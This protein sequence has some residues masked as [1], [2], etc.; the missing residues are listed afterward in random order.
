MPGDRT[1]FAD[2]FSDTPIGDFP[3][4]LRFKSGEMEVVEWNGRSLL[5]VQGNRQDHFE[6]PLPETLPERFLE[7]EIYD[8]DSP[9]GDV[10]RAGVF[11]GPPPANGFSMTRPGGE[12]HVLVSNSDGLGIFTYFNEPVSS[13]EG[14][15]TP[16]AQGLTRIEVQVDGEA[17]SLRRR[18]TDR[19]MSPRSTWAADAITVLVQARRTRPTSATSA[20]R[21]RG[22][23]YSAYH[24]PTGASPPGTSS[25]PAARLEPS[26]TAVLT[27]IAATCSSSTQAAPAHVEGT[28]TTPTAP[29]R[30]LSLSQQRADAVRDRLVAGEGIDPSRLEAVGMGEEHPVA[31][32]ATGPN[33]R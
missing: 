1:L 31:D 23:L 5:R 33:G 9:G 10:D 21:R 7:F 14:S 25:R 2:D 22:G 6:I 8:A 18:R 13:V 17:V 16:L 24:A 15:R 20:G 30:S 27:Q 32:N 19:P 26:S 12:P 28:P 11:F 4:R 29:S 3:H